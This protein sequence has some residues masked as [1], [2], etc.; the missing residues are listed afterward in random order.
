MLI[1]RLAAYEASL[2][3][4][5]SA[6]ASGLKSAL[7]LLVLSLSKTEKT[8]RTTQVESQ[9]RAL[10]RDGSIPGWVQLFQAL[11][12]SDRD[13]FLDAAERVFTD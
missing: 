13:A 8:N 10:E 1:E 9:I 3:F 7:G 2:P 12:R 4:L 5:E 6:A 11:A